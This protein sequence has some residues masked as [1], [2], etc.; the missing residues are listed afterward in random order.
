MQTEDPRLSGRCRAVRHRQTR[1][2][3][4]IEKPGGGRVPFADATGEPHRQRRVLRQASALVP[5]ERELRVGDAKQS[6]DVLKHGGSY[7]SVSTL[8]DVP[9]G[10]VIV[11]RT[12]PWGITG[13]GPGG[14]NRL[15]TAPY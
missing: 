4:L 2:Q 12:R 15:I 9:S 7:S 6:D 13:N 10:A 14:K 3:R 8:T 5:R 11:T 1:R